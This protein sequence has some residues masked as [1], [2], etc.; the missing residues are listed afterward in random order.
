M[1]SLDLCI[2]CSPALPA[3]GPD[4]F[5]FFL[6]SVSYEG[7]RE[8]ILEVGFDQLPGGAYRPWFFNASA[9]TPAFLAEKPLLFGPDLALVEGGA[10][11]AGHVVNYLHNL[12]FVTVHGSGHMVPQFRPQAALTLLRNLVTAT[13]FAAPLGDDA[14]LSAMTDDQ[15]DTYLDAWTTAAKS[16]L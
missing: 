7:T 9:A 14:A 13:P 1:L 6:R 2:T 5:L 8:A 4:P 3:R 15:F 11:F 10:Q 16:D 12:S